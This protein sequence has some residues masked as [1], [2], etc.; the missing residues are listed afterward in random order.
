[1]RQ[2]ILS[3]AAAHEEM[4]STRGEAIAHAL[5]SMAAPPV[6]TTAQRTAPVL[7]SRTRTGSAAASLKFAL[8]SFGISAFASLTIVA[9]N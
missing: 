1:M 2:Q 6:A 3:V 9:A 5:N 4:G 8:W 7:A